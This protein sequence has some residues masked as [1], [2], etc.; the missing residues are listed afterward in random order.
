MTRRIVRISRGLLA[1][2]LS[3]YAL[4]S[5][6]TSHASVP[7]FPDLATYIPVDV[8]DYQVEESSPGHTN[9]FT[10]FLTPDGI[11]CSFE[12]TGAGCVASN[13]PGVSVPAPSFPYSDGTGFTLR[14][15]VF[16][17]STNIWLRSFSSLPADTSN[18]KT[19]PPGHSITQHG[20]TC[21]VDAAMMTACIDPQGQGFMLSPTWSGWLPHVT[22][23]QPLTA[24]PIHCRITDKGI[25]S[26]RDGDHGFSSSRDGSGYHAY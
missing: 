10:K 22:P 14:T 18:V 5:A 12:S 11:P 4:H 17:I 21:G 15:G 9:I 6:P 2:A 24:E 7:V 13:F 8:K 20:L 16:G 3:A 19:L 23:G 1:C 26:C 25:T